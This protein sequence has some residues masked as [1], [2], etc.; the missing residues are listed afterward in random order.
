MIISQEFQGKNILILERLRQSVKT[1]SKSPN[2]RYKLTHK[3][4]RDESDIT[5]VVGSDVTYW[6]KK[7]ADDMLKNGLFNSVNLF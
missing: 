2:Y 6:T 3:W 7:E 4:L 1:W 5:S